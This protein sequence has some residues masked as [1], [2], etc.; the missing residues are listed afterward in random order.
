[1][2]NKKV[3]ELYRQLADKLDEIEA[4]EIRVKTQE[5]IIRNNDELLRIANMQV[6]FASSEA[7]EWKVKAEDF[8]QM[9][10]RYR[11]SSEYRAILL[12]KIDSLFSN[13]TEQD[14][15][16]LE[17]D[18]WEAKGLISS[19]DYS[20]MKEYDEEIEH[21]DRIITLAQELK[22]IKGEFFNGSEGEEDDIDEQL[23]EF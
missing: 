20:T 23:A 17:A 8:R 19:E 6:K 11:E 18:T 9:A 21:A 10:V 13:Y 5:E 4:L 14:F 12:T 3:S 2:S 16:D 7:E 15:I 1:M 22:F